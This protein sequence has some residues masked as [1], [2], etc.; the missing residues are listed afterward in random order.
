MNTL[1][2]CM[3]K[4][5]YPYM[6]KELKKIQNQIKNK[7]C[8]INELKKSKEKIENTPLRFVNL[9]KESNRND[10]IIVSNNLNAEQSILAQL[11]ERE[12][13]VKRDDRN[14]YFTSIVTTL[15]VLTSII[16]ILI[17]LK[18]F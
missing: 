4:I 13:Y 6:S 16:D 3:E 9:D 2:N 8:I 7:I 5:I 12:L 17:K 10:L 1:Y 14:K 15:L 11:E 18:I